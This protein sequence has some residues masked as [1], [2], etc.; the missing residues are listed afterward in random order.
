MCCSCG[1]PLPSRH[2]LTWNCPDRPV[3]EAQTPCN[4]QASLGVSYAK[5]EQPWAGIRLKRLSFVGCT[6]F[7]Q[8][9][10]LPYPLWGC[11]TRY[12]FTPWR[13]RAGAALPCFAPG[14]WK[15]VSFLSPHSM[16]HFV[17]SHGFRI[18][19]GVLQVRNSANLWHQLKSLAD[20]KANSLAH[21][22][23]QHIKAFCQ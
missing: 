3:L 10:A 7:D 23:F 16:L 12:S 1:K 19:L 13:G 6:R 2:H 17:P 18:F 5:L 14:L 15:E 22:E 9:V 8:G 4:H 11:L 20:T 21:R